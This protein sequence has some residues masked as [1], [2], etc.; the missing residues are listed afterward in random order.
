MVEP[1]SVLRAIFPSND[2]NSSN[3]WYTP[4]YLMDAVRK[5]MKV[6]YIDLDP[7]SCAEANKIVKAKRYYTIKDDGLSKNWTGENVWL[8]PPRGTD[9]RISIQYI[10]SKRVY[11]HYRR[12]EIKEALFIVRAVLGY[13]WFNEIWN[14]IPDVC[15]LD[16]RPA[17]YKGFVGDVANQDQLTG[18]IF[19]LGEDPTE[20]QKVFTH[21]GRVFDKNSY[22]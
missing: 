11:L 5:V 13:L 4:D 15:F 7:A 8:N 1:S 12:K 21:L 19:Y 14:L 6:G 22:R 10:W 17:Y 20:F 2:F 16:E 3:E 9:E 18:A